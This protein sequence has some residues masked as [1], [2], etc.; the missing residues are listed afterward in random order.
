MVN[1]IICSLTFKE[2]FFF[3]FFFPLGIL[4]LVPLPMCSNQKY[5]SNRLRPQYTVTLTRLLMSPLKQCVCLVKTAPRNKLCLWSCGAPSGALTFFLWPTQ[6]MVLH[7]LENSRC[8]LLC[9]RRP[10]APHLN[11][12]CSFQHASICYFYIFQQIYLYPYCWLL[13]DFYA[14]VSFSGGTRG[15]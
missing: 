1:V 13:I 4:L 10:V 14:C 7:A 5:H 3:F 2:P 6:H 15:Q 8:F 12:F 11:V 9:P